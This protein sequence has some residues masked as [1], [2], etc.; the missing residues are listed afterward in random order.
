MPAKHLSMFNAFKIIDFTVWI[1]KKTRSIPGIYRQ[2][3]RE[4]DR[5]ITSDIKPWTDMTTIAKTDLRNLTMV[6]DKLQM[7]LRDHL[8]LNGS[9]EHITPHILIDNIINVAERANYILD[10]FWTECIPKHLV[11]PLDRSPCVFNS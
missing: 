10:T 6:I 4:H 2:Q 5:T 1:E 7:Y 8:H 11:T 3:L 9:F